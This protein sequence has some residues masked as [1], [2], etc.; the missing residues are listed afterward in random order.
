LFRKPVI[1]GASETRKLEPR[2][3]KRADG[4][5]V[6]VITIFL[7]GEAF[8]PEAI[9]SVIA[10]SFKDWELLLV[11]DGSG[12]AATAIAKAY[13][14]KY[15][16]Q[17]RYFEHPGHT[18][19]GMSATRNLGIKHAR[20]EFIAFIDADD[21]WLPSKLADQVALLDAHPD[22]GMVCGSAIYWNSWSNGQDYIVPTG[23]RQDVIIHPPDATLAWYPLGTAGAPCPSDIVLRAE[24]VKRLGGFEE[25]FTGNYQL[26]EDQG[27]LAKV[28]LSTP[29]W[30]C[31]SPLLKYRNHPDSCVATVTKAGKYDQVRLYFLE[32]FETYLKRQGKVDWR[33]R[34]SL[35]RALR[36]Y[37]NPRMHYM[38][39]VPN[40]V[41]NRCRRLSARA[42][43]LIW[44]H[45]S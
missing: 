29:V 3:S 31:S 17:I 10:Q 42:G 41:R 19:R 23:H 20:G 26:Y 25:H 6:S 16:R 43:R 32:W 18:N 36:Y 13:A 21:F 8:L 27:F 44:G 38:L 37:R 14:A 30:S 24:L 7:D 22:V 2:K 45:A 39:S 34:S 15:P 35:R 4:P 1:K 5:R 28:Y 12:P 40:K 9:E 11:D 33:V